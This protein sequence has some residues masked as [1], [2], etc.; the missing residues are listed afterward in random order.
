[1]STVLILIE[2]IQNSY[3]Q[4][5]NCKQGFCSKFCI[6]DSL[7]PYY[8]ST[9]DRLGHSDIFRV[10]YVNRELRCS[11]VTMTMER[12]KAGEYAACVYEVAMT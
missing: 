10:L 3:V 4:S 5:C 2:K 8:L 12:S 9:L 11:L 1:M 7:S 6:T